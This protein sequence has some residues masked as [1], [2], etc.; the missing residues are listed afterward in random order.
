MSA[1][2]KQPTTPEREADLRAEHPDTGAKEGGPG[3]SSLAASEATFTPRRFL[4]N[5]HLQTLAG[6]FL[7]RQNH[8]P[9]PEERLVPGGEKVPGAGPPHLPPHRGG[10]PPP[11]YLPRL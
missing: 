10:G 11:P 6:N 2:T 5:N 3:E 1:N 8:P 7:P 9:P 4:R